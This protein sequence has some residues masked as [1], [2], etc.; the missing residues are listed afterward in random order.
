MRWLPNALTF[1]RL[2]SSPILVWLLLEYRYR[3]A[4]VLVLIAGL[5]DW[6][7]GYA[8]RRLGTGGKT[9]VVLD[10]LADKALLV[11]LFQACCGSYRGGW[12]ES[13]LAG[14]LLFLVER[15]CCEFFAASS[16]FS[17]RCSG[18]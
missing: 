10:P 7:D 15:F 8:A 16:D 3:E 14:T 17:L 6:L 1:L 12:S 13:L 5:T 18:R 2:G 4:L 11:T 9:G